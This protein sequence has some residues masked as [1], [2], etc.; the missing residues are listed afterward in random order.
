[1]KKRVK[2]IAG[3]SAA[4]ILTAAGTA[5]YIKRSA[6]PGEEWIAYDNETVI[7][8]IDRQ[9]A[10]LDIGKIVEEKE[11]YIVE[12]GVKEIQKAVEEGL[13]TYE[14]IT[15]V[16][17]YRIKTID[18]KE[19]GYNSVICVN[20]RAIDEARKKDME[21]GKN[22]EHQNGIYGIPI[23][24]KDNINASGMPCSAGTVA[25]SGYYP[26]SDAGL[27]KALKEEGAV[28]LGKNNLSELSYYVSG[29]MPAGYSAVKGQTINPYGPLKLSAY[30]SSSGSAVAVTANLAP[31]CIGTETDGSIIAPSAANSVTGFKPTRGTIPGDGIFPLIKEIDMAGPIAKTVEDA[32]VV[33]RMISGADLPENFPA[34]A[35]KGKTVGL[36]GYEYSDGEMMSLLRQKLE[37]TGARVID[38]DLDTS[39]IITFNSISLS[40]K[41]EFED[42]T[43]AGR[44]P[45]RKLNELL[46]YNREDPERRM[47]YGQDLLE[48]A[49]KTDRPDTDGI[50][51]SVR[52]AD[53]A[54]TAVF[55]E[56]HLDA[57]VFLNSSGS[58]APAL[59]GYPELT[60]PFGKDRK[61]M[62]QGATFTARKGEDRKLLGMG[63]SFEHHVQGRLIP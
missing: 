62:P 61:G 47:R 53:D 6:P 52:R 24:L 13:L 18:Q 60:V 9:L 51:E 34:D 19:K 27:V 50:K 42:Y 31:V 3:I 55:D 57:L 45:I 23:M 12:K 1:M 26:P 54:L 33:Y 25:F 28:I 59:A 58:T 37:E 40:F 4:V 5:L 39:G 38:A 49:E 8:S 63:Y 29:I 10:G 11:G 48:E 14:E 46:E 7:L 22:Q 15:A 32:A 17:L 35:L 21:R 41:K 20:P 16:C 30:G 43:A 44:Y 2:I 56:Y 36:L